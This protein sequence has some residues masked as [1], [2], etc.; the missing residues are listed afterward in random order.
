MTQLQRSDWYAVARDTNWTPSFVAEAD[1]FPPEISDP[2][3]MPK[4]AWAEYDEPYKVSYAEYV[5]VQRE[6]DAGVY[7]VNTA[8]ARTRFMEEAGERWHS[9]LN[10]HLEA[11]RPEPVDA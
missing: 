1:L 2:F 11:P 7:A 9:I 4:A 5:K 6:K 8:A 10:L 3:N